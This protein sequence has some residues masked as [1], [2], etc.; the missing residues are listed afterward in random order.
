M[1]IYDVI[2][3]GCGSAGIGAGIEFEKSKCNIKYL[4]L[5]G[6][7]RIGGRSFTDM[8][9]FGAEIPVDLGAHYICHHQENNF[10]FKNFLRSDKDFIES[11]V[12]DGSIMKIFDRN[13]T[14]ISDE[15]ILKSTEIVDGLMRFIRANANLDQDVSIQDLIHSKLEGISDEQVRNLVNLFLAY[16]ELHEGSDLNQISALSFGRGEADLEETDLSIENGL[17]NVVK[18]IA[19]KYQLPI[20]LHSIVTNIDISNDFVC[21]KTKDQQ[22][23]KCKYVLITIPLGCLKT[24]TIQFH[25]ELPRWKQDAIE[26]MGFSLLNKVYLQFSNIFW[27]K[28]LRRI[29]VLDERF[30]F[31]YCL[32]EYSMLALYISGSIARQLENLTDEQMIN[33]IVHSLRRIYPQI[34]QPT[35]WLITRWSQDPFS[36]GSYSSFHRG[37]TIETLEDLSKDTHQGKIHWAGEHTN[38][39]GCIGYV[40]SGFESGFR[41]GKA[42]LSKLQL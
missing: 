35:K 20:K 31:Y 37:N 8:T 6:R 30:K 12:Y 42:L 33:E 39:N 10:L 27:E 22:I 40:D 41:E 28:H 1:E 26:Q 5:E 18:Q 23:Y 13:G 3:V 7:D 38:F 19:D 29:T 15:I 2:I 4:I 11:D 16:T 34:T 36:F 24:K 9:T 21:V 32:P 17:G 14:A 25:P